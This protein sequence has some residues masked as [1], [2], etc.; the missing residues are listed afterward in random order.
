M[1]TPNKKKYTGPELI[2]SPDV[3]TG[4][5][6]SNMMDEITL[7]DKNP[8]IV[9]F[10][11]PKAMGGTA[12]MPSGSLRSI[13]SVAKNLPKTIKKGKEF[14]S[15]I[16]KA[17]KYK[18]GET[19]K[20]SD[21][22]KDVW[23][24]ATKSKEALKTWDKGKK[25]V[26]RGEDLNKFTRQIDQGTFT[27]SKS[28]QNSPNFKKGSLFSGSVP[29]DKSF[30]VTRKGSQGFI[31]N[32]NKVNLSSFKGTRGSAGVGVLKPGSRSTKNLQY[33]QFDAPK[34]VYRKIDPSKLKKG[35]SI[36]LIKKK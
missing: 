27:L 17:F 28:N 36:K 13:I 19:L 8:N 9:K 14:L 22:P 11:R 33:Y 6:Y 21:I 29:K 2:K 25:I 18:Y 32:L 34:S 26:G 4:E 5:Q 24:H 7:T 3:Y 20:T 15:A 12:P 10:D 31:P 1:P 30:L 16:K 35:G 23:T